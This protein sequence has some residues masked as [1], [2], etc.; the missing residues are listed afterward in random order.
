MQASNWIEGAL[1]RSLIN[2]KKKA[3]RRNA[4]KEQ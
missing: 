1:A 2:A 3:R 4:Q